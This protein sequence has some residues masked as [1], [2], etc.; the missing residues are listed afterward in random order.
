MCP[1]CGGTLFELVE[2][3]VERYRCRVGHG[4]SLD[5]LNAAQSEKVEDALWAS[6]RALEEHGETSRRAAVLARAR[7]M[8]HVARAYE[9]R[10]GDNDRQ[11]EVV[12]KALTKKLS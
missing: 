12:R 11:A 10:A 2:G 1:D 6:L 4:Y 5:T 7:G 9:E 8:D 3:G